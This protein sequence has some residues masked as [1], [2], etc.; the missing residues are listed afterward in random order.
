M[1]AAA[2]PRS[3][4]EHEDGAR[5]TSPLKRR[6]CRGPRHE[7]SN[8]EPEPAKVPTR[9]DNQST[10]FMCSSCDTRRHLTF[11]CV[12]AAR[13]GSA[14]PGLPTHRRMHA[15]CMAIYACAANSQLES[16][17]LACRCLGKSAAAGT[18]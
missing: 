10:G 12:K 4:S 17:A 1:R 8:P 5:S 7:E 3:S 9:V 15:D 14:Q 2:A 11:S 16:A 13:I 18:C 6:S